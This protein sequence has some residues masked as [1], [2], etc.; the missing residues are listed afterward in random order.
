MSM[1]R[2]HARMT[3]INHSKTPF[4]IFCDSSN[5]IKPNFVEIALRQLV[6]PVVSSCFG[7][8]LNHEE[9]TDTFSNWRGKHLFGQ[10]KLYRKEV[11]SV[12]C[13]ITYAVLMRKDH[14]IEVGNFNPKL[15][16]CE[17]QDLGEK[18]IRSN[19]KIISDPQLIAYS[20]RKESFHS[21]CTRFR[22][23]RS[24]HNRVKNT[25]S[26][27]YTTLKIAFLI[28]AR[29]DLREKKFKCLIISVALPFYLLVQ[30]LLKRS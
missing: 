18:L 10:N 20:I 12:D 25:F 9:L 19:Y 13:L 7:R 17:D 22:R 21:L 2:G 30:D 4:V 28:F 26:E 3:G 23:W 15:R 27:F 16:Q 29:E 11:H 5:I 8:I 24:N 14:V 6:N 1:G